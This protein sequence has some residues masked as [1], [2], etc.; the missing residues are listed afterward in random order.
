MM[1]HPQR[2]TN[3]RNIS[4]VMKGINLLLVSDHGDKRNVVLVCSSSTTPNSLGLW[5]FPDTWFKVRVGGELILSVLFSGGMRKEFSAGT[6]RNGCN[7]IVLSALWNVLLELVEPGA[8][9]GT[10]R[11]AAA[12]Q[13]HIMTRRKEE[14][15]CFW[16][17]ILLLT[18]RLDGY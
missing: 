16:G 18:L 6:Q 4:R 9:E 11:E 5:D 15:V 8:W 2:G 1:Y 17:V 3:D 14:C 7:G 12:R 10:S 13:D